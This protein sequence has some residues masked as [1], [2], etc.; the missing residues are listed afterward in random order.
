MNDVK[1]DL[2]KICVLVGVQCCWV[3]KLSEAGAIAILNKLHK[4][5]NDERSGK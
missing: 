5:L 2:E 3:D 1:T 4:L